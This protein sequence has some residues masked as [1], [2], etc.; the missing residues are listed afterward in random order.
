LKSTSHAAKVSAKD[1]ES[2]A[3][4]ISN[5]T[6]ID[7]EAIQSG[8]NLL[9]TFTNI[10]NEVGKGNDIFSQATMTIT[11][12]SVALGQ[13]MKTSAIQV[14]KALND[15][16]KGMS[17]LRRVGVSFT[18]DQEKQVKA[19]V[20]SGKT[21]EAQKIIL[22]ELN[23]EFGGSAVAAAT[24]GDK[25]KVAADNIK[26]AFG[27]KML[28]ALEKVSK[29]FTEEGADS[30]AAFT[31]SFDAQ[32][33]EDAAD[34]VILIAEG[35]TTLSKALGKWD[36]SNG[37]AFTTF[38]V[39][40]GVAGEAFTF[41]KAKILIG[42]DEVA[43]A[44]VR[45]GF[46]PKRV[47]KA[48]HDMRVKA[49]ADMNAMAKDINNKKIVAKLR[50]DKKDAQAK[51]KDIN[52]QLKR[53]ND[54]KVITRLKADK[55]SAQAAIA[56]IRAQLNRLNGKTAITYIKTIRTT[57]QGP[58]SAGRRAAGGFISGAEGYGSS[59]AEG[60]ARTGRVLV[61]EQGPEIVDLP[62]GSHVNSN[63]DS[64]RM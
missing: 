49:E 10:R 5:K 30:I 14:G 27:K 58:N 31:D 16:I 55:A 22:A 54:A 23:K 12:M 8:E 35:V 2:L 24:W 33:M 41:W 7:D 32:K 6:G 46:F 9:L 20:K 36:K 34:S 1:V 28:P 25:A 21:M 15:P 50:A 57:A 53:T 43:Q 13:D 11:D 38:G 61:G 3:T 18:E 37:R 17:A 56:N 44:G 47:A 52:A 39:N 42:M 64:Q 48:V 29:W 4:A 59:A 62:L 26:E 45:L 19:L 40:L 60:G 63:P 51:V